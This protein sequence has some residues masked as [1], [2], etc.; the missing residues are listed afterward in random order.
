MIKNDS[1][2]YNLLNVPSC[3]KR[4]EIFYY[5]SYHRNSS[6]VNDGVIIIRPNL[7]PIIGTFYYFK[8]CHPYFLGFILLL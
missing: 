5:S 8:F 2:V 3:T 6:H 1:N 7:S 4:L